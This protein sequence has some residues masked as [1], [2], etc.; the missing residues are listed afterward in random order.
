[1][2]IKKMLEGITIIDLSR[3]LAAPFATM[4][5]SDLGAN[6]IKVEAPEVGDDARGYGPLINGKSGYFMSI[7]RGK[8]AITLNLK[9]EIGIEILEKLLKHADAMVDN[10]RPGVLDKLGLTEDRLKEI[11]PRLVFAS[12]TGFGHTGPYAHKAAYDLVAQGYGGMMSITGLE[13]SE[14]TKVG[15]SIGDLAGG[16]YLAFGIVSALLGREKSGEGDRI[17]IAMLDCQVALLENAIIRYTASGD[18]PKPIG[19]RHPSITPFEMFPSKDGHVIICVGNEKNWK[20]LCHVLGN[21]EL[22]LDKRF[23]S[24]DLRTINHDA[25]FEILANTLQTKNT[26]EWLQMFDLEGIPCG[27]VN[28][29]KDVVENEQVIARNMIVSIDYPNVGIVKSPGCPIKSRE[30]LI[31]SSRPSPDLSQ[32]NIEIL[33]GMGLSLDEIDS[34]KTKKII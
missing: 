21:S 6:V 14:P 31:D 1:M 30:Y 27:P 32:D 4:L 26:S 13:G 5:L 22:N 34:L 15:I 29:I 12:I 11:N 3:N 24:N 33:S 20:A 16:L 19:N 2:A 8:K 18:I 7:N 28:N 17:D 23:Q 9:T 10:F 25:L